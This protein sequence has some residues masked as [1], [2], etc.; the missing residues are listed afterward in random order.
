MSVDVKISTGP[1]LRERRRPLTGISVVLP[2]HDE[3]ANVSAA[4][5]EALRAAERAADAAE[6]IVVDDGSTDATAALAREA[7]AHDRRVRLVRHPRNRGYGAAVR[8]GI[9]AARMPWVLLTDGDLQFDLAE[10]DR[11]TGPAAEADLVIGW[12]VARRDPLPRRIDGAAWN[13]LV[14]V[15]LDLH[16][17]DVDC[18]F[19]L[20]RRELLDGLPLTCD[21]AAVSAEL[22]A[23]AARRGARVVEVGVS[24]RPRRAGRQSGARLDVVMRALRELAAVRGALGAPVPAGSGLMDDAELRAMLTHDERHWWYRGRLRVLRAVLDTLPLPPDAQIL[25]AGCGSGRVLDELAR[26]GAVSGVD[27]SELALRC[28]RRRGHADVHR[29]SVE[30]LPFP[31]GRF[32]LVTCLDVVEHTPDDR[33][34]LAELRRVTRAGGRLV[35]TVPAYQRLWSAH[36]VVN[37]HY[38]RYDTSRLTAAARA[39][40]WTVERTTHFNALLLPPA[41]VVRRLRRGAPP[42]RSELTLTPPLLDRPLELPLAAEAWAIR[43]GLRIPAGLSLLAVLAA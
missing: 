25:D 35:V 5:A 4:V 24:H 37:G 26:R 13:A 16:V 33:A 31:A 19:K 1:L 17:R 28:A 36:D 10:L 23:H 41:A 42:G 18:A 14:R 27:L 32:D 11:F 12:R 9:A 8:S 3:E 7:C 29:A 43:Q 22:L 40:G 30:R 21:G 38:R 39:A 34:T 20:M 6:V 2:C 15:A